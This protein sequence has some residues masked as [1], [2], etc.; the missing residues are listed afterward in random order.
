[1]ERF[2]STTRLNLVD[3]HKCETGLPYG[4]TYH[5]CRFCGAGWPEEPHLWKYGVRHYACD[6]CRKAALAEED[7]SRRSMQEII[8]RIGR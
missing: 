6:R 5:K 7:E 1:M 8:S 3:A 2:S 4:L